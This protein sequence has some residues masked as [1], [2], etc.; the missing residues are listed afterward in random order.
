ME[1]L[2]YQANRDESPRSDIKD[3]YNNCRIKYKNEKISYSYI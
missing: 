3:L 1:I 2:G